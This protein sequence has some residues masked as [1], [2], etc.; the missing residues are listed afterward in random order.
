MVARSQS[1]D[2]VDITSPRQIDANRINTKRGTGP[3]MEAGT[4]RAS[5]NAF[6]HGRQDLTVSRLRAC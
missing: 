4:V 3:T 5:R 2:K 1:E 6:R